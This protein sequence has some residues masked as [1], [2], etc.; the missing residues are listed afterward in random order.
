M[1]LGPCVPL[2]SERGAGRDGNGRGTRGTAAVADDVGAAS[3]V[4]LD[5]AEISVGGRP[6]RTRRVVRVVGVGGGVEVGVALAADGDGLD[7]AVGC[8]RGRA[9]KKGKERLHDGKPKGVG[10]FEVRGKGSREEVA[11]LSAESR[12]YHEGS[13]P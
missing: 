11:F 2:E 13:I 8:D 3:R 5:E 6:T 4:G 9:E 7:E 1:R 12:A 10:R